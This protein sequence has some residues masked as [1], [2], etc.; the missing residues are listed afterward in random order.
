MTAV[1]NVNCRNSLHVRQLTLPIVGVIWLAIYPHLCSLHCLVLDGPGWNI[2][3]HYCY[4][5]CLHKSVTGCSSIYFVVTSGVLICS[6]WTI[7]L[8][9]SNITYFHIVFQCISDISCF[10]GHFVNSS[11]QQLRIVGVTAAGS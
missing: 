3:Y 11:T 7:Y 2:V 5:S 4:R 6:V 8:A 10:V 1:C 9:N